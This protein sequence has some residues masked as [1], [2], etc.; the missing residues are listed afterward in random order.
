MQ[1]V[2]ALEEICNKIQDV[3]FSPLVEVLVHGHRP[4][5]SVE[6]LRG[7]A[8]LLGYVYLCVKFFPS[9]RTAINDEVLSG[10]GLCSKMTR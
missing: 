10:I 1:L 5:T 8:V 9:Y 4:Q 7:G 6:I 2:V 3:F